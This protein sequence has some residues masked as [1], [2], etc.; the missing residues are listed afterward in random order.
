MT[1]FPAPRHHIPDD[2]LLGHAA[3]G[4]GEAESL[5]VATHLTMCAA[6]RAQSAALDAWGGAMLEEVSP[7]SVPAELLASTLSQL[8]AP[9]PPPPPPRA[10]PPELAALPLPEP[11]RSCVAA[12]EQQRWKMLLPGLVYQL[13][14][15]VSWGSTPVRLTRVRG[16]FKVPPHTHT[17]RELSLVLAGGFHDRGQGYAPGDITDWDEQVTHALHIDPGEDCLILAVNEAPLVPVGL[18]SKVVS[19]I[20]GY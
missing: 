19:W 9:I 5:L 15:P 3:G 17:G 2:L 1:P 20:T 7:Q 18:S 13:T 6:C 11:L 8:D 10:L 14:L 4:L 12:A 16:G